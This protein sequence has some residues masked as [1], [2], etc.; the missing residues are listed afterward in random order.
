MMLNLHKG[1]PHTTFKLGT[2]L[3]NTPPRVTLHKS[4]T[5]EV[6]VLTY[7]ITP[8]SFPNSDTQVRVRDE[9]RKVG[10]GTLTM[11]CFQEWSIPGGLAPEG[12]ETSTIYS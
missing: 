9:S 4:S 6:T 1:F 11:S 10:G 3:L 5:L 7:L 8:N 2:T 12:S